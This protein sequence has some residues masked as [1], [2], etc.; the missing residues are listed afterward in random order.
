MS[1]VENPWQSPENP[2]APENPQS[3]QAV[4]TAVMMGYLKAAS[5][6]LRFLGILGFIGSGLMILGGII[7]ASFSSFILNFLEEMATLPSGFTL[8]Y[9]ALGVI[10]FFP[11]RFTYLFGAKIRDYALSN[12][13]K[14]LES[15]LKNNRSLWKFNG[16]L[17]IVYL[18]LI[19]LGIICS[20]IAL[21]VCL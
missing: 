6:W 8:I 9:V 21:T 7:T 12:S 19:P 17:S 1:D 10:N 18:A 11:A 20:I 14:D 13:E 5:P 2:S 4:L 15:A 3:H 16:I